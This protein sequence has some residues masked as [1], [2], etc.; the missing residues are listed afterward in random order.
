MSSKPSGGFFVLVVRI[1]GIMDV[2]VE[3]KEIP[4]S[5][6]L[7]GKMTEHRVHIASSLPRRNIL[8]T[9][10]SVQYASRQLSNRPALNCPYNA[11]RGPYPSL[12]HALSQRI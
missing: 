12:V 4:R 8:L 3:S 1:L 10:H 11:A 5:R 9:A 6:E 7:L 2:D